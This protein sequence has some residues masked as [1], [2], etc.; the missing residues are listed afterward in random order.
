M[1]TV[2]V[3]GLSD[4]DV[5]CLS[6]CLSPVAHMR[7]MFRNY[8]TNQRENV[9]QCIETMK[10]DYR[11]QYYDVITN[12]RWRTHYGESLRRYISVKIDQIMMKF[13]R[14]KQILTSITNAMTKIQI[15][16]FKMVEGRRIIG[17]HRFGHNSVA[18]CAILANFLGREQ[19]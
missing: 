14:L 4:A 10:V 2:V 15:F 1:T 17:K 8:Q 16:K 5:R 13:G 19:A 18:D 6:V 12:P 7:G 3:K 9:G 11:M